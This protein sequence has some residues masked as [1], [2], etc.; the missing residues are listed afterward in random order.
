MDISEVTYIEEKAPGTLVV[1]T[2]LDVSQRSGIH[3]RA[4]DPQIDSCLLIAVIPMNAIV[5]LGTTSSFKIRPDLVSMGCSNG[6]TSSCRDLRS[7]KYERSPMLIWTSA[8]TDAMIMA[9]EGGLD[10][11]SILSQHY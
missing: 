4:F 6:R 5:P 8:H 3:S 11:H 10:A 9:L 7:A 2:G 1:V